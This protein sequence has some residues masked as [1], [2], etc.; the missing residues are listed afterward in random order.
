MFSAL[1]SQ[2]FAES[3]CLQWAAG[4]MLSSRAQ[5]LSRDAGSLSRPLTLS[6]PLEAVRPEKA[7]SRA[8]GQG[9]Q[10]WKG[11]SSRR[12]PRG[13]TAGVEGRGPRRGMTAH[14][15]LPAG[16][17]S[18][19]CSPPV[20]ITGGQ[21]AGTGARGKKKNPGIQVPAHGRA[22]LTSTSLGRAGAS[23]SWG[24]AR[25]P[26][27]RCQGCFSGDELFIS[28]FKGIV[29][30]QFLISVI[31]IFNSVS[32][33]FFLICWIFVACVHHVCNPF[34]FLSILTYIL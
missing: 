24:V 3:W 30:F 14:W 21:R 5:G 1:F 19:S 12:P 23:L 13:R 6:I 10:F 25:L 27:V 32:S 20:K 33:M 15:H 2:R 26:R 22:D 31:M 7:D 34:Y 28:C 29:K 18:R 8:P 11:I 9:G 16:P 17:G 4:G